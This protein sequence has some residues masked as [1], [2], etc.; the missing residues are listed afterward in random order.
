MTG[1]S[2]AGEPHGIS[3]TEAEVS[4]APASDAGV[5]GGGT[6]GVTLAPNSSP[7]VRAG[8]LPADA[9]VAGREP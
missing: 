1:Q 2:G 7:A 9:L 6:H 3:Q 4:Q 8:C 5:G